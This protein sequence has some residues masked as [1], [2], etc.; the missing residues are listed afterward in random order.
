[1]ARKI[2][3]WAGVLIG[4]AVLF[5]AG[6]AMVLIFA[7]G[8]EIFGVRWIGKGLSQFQQTETLSSFSGDIYIETHGAPIIITYNDYYSNNVEFAQ[9]FMGFTKTEYDKAN[10]SITY[11]LGDVHIKANEM[12]GFLYSKLG[13]GDY[14]LKLNLSTASMQGRNVYVLGKN[15]SLKI[16]G[17]ARYGKL[18]FVSNGGFEVENSVVATDLKIHTG[19][20]LLIDEKIS[21]T[22]YDLKS[23]GSSI[24]I[25][26]QI[27]GKL[28][29]E[30]TTGE[31]RFVSCNSLEATTESGTVRGYGEG[32]NL[33]RGAANVKT[34]SGSVILGNVATIDN[35][36]KCVISSL[37]GSVSVTNMYDGEITTERGRVFV[38][39]ARSLVVTAYLGNV[40]VNHISRGIVVNGRNGNV[41]VGN[42]GYA[43]DVTVYTTTGSIDIS[44]AKGEIIAESTNGNI[45]LKND[46]SNKMSLKAGRKLTAEGLQGE[47]YAY[48]KSGD[49]NLKF[50]KID[51]NVTIEVG[52]KC[53]NVFVDATC[54]S[55]ENVNYKLE[56]T[57]GTKA[58]VFAGDLLLSENT[59]IESKINPNN[60]TITMTSSYAHMVLKFAV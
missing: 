17:N 44:N 11:N 22:N 57:K 58:K 26:K 20:Y 2:A 46:G 27:P 41:S 31:I 1:M 24:H 28:K 40:D 19:K 29:A 4:C 39:T 55:Y 52:S 25:S 13:T 60:P 6:C 37:S 32:L 10:I 51:A 16:V 5:F 50:D 8:V 3:I 48:A 34:R 53:D 56:S 12:V 36:A 9:D 15:S 30:T 49:M 14:F 23:S 35:S 7:P 43:K 47:V 59:K 42:N 54:V 45:T 21:A 38:D 18:E 33:V